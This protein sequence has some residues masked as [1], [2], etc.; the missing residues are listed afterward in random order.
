[1][2]KIIQ[3]EGNLVVRYYAGEV[4]ENYIKQVTGMYVSRWFNIF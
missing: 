4:Q 3:V 1:M 2:N